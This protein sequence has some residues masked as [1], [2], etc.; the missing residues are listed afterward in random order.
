M[1]DKIPI[2]R[3]LHH[4]DHQSSHKKIFKIFFGSPIHQE[5]EFFHLDHDVDHQSY[6]IGLMVYI[7]KE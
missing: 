3:K 5:E 6:K 7:N 1:A 2:R 4:P